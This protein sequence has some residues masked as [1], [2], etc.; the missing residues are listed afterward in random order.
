[1]NSDGNK[2]SLNL[3]NLLEVFKLDA[4]SIMAIRSQ[5]HLIL[6]YEKL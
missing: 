5:T 2:R 3:T 1:M 4:N 6:K